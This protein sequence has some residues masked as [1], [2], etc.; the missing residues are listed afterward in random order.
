[1]GKSNVLT[2]MLTGATGFLGGHLMASLI[3]KD[4]RVI[5]LGR[6]SADGNLEQRILK[7][8]KWFGLEDRYKQVETAEADLLKPFCGLDEQKF[9]SLCSRTDQVIH[10][11]SD[12]RFS[13][14]NRK[15]IS[16]ANIHSLNG[17][18]D[19]ARHSNAAWLHYIST[20]Y[21]AGTTSS[22]CPEKLSSSEEFSNVYEETKAL[23]EKVIAE[24]CEL[25]AIP[26]TI[27][28]PSIVYGDSQ[29]GRSNGFNALYSHVKSL[30]YIREIYINDIKKNKGLKSAESKVYLDEAGILHIPLN[31]FVPNDGIINLIP[32]DYFVAASLSVIEKPASGNI[33]HIT[34]NNPKSLKE[35]ALYCESFLK[36]KGIRI[37]CEDLPAG[38]RYSPAE[39]LLAKFLEPYFPYLSDTRI[40]D[41]CNLDKVMENFYPPEF[42]YDI[43]KRCMEYAV[44]VNWG[45]E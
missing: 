37:I 20:A 27:L 8:L 35:L 14:Y 28:R 3:R 45:K 25:N 44:S 16:D 12:T 31:M 22:L 1:M 30:Y 9:N 24:Q 7:L 36:I 21:V 43:F 29:T 10:C 17:I 26:Y 15:E 18:I 39:A 13:E 33:Y 4:H 2:F 34:D 38:F 11:A 42:T 6:P 5:I 32:I 41:R 23:A 19:Y 40:F